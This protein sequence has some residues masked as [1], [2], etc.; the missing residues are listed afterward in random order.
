MHL[1]Q[2]FRLDQR[3]RRCA[4]ILADTR[5]KN[6]ILS[7]FDDLTAHDEGREVLIAI[8]YDVGEALTS[9]ASI[10]YDDEGFILAKAAIQIR[11]DILGSKHREDPLQNA[12]NLTFQHLSSHLSP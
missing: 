6:R 12:K 4:R 11:R 7:Q 10:N 8:N 9:A 1:V 3:V 5:L 2:S